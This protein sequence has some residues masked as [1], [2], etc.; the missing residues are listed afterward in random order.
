M[1][2]TVTIAARS[3]GTYVAHCPALPGCQIKSEQLDD[4]PDEME[5]L[6]RGYLAS[7]HR[8]LPKKPFRLTNAHRAAE[9]MQVPKRHE[10]SEGR[11]E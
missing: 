3:D 11:Y 5:R 1:E 10:C 7:L 8:P 4:L 6:V 2:L 9:R